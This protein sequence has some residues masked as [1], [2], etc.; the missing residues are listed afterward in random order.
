[1]ADKTLLEEVNERLRELEEKYDLL[2][3]QVDG[4][5]VWPILR[6]VVAGELLNYPF[7]KKEGP[8]RRKQLLRALKGLSGLFTLRKARYF[9]KTYSSARMEQEDGLYKDVFFD[10]LLVEL[11][12]YFKLEAENNNNFLS[13]SQAAFIKSDLSTAPIDLLTYLLKKMG[14]R[15]DLSIVASRLSDCLQQE[16][17]LKAF[18]TQRVNSYIL[19]FY[20]QKKVYTWLLRRVGPK[21]VLTADWGEWSIN[22]AAKELGIK[23]IDFQHGSPNRYHYAYSWSAYAVPYKAQMP[24][25]TR[26][27]LYGEYFEQELKAY[28]FWNKELCSVGGVRTNQY[29]KYKAAYKTSADNST[30]TMVVTSQGIDVERIIAFLDAFLKLAKGKLELR[31][32]IKPHPVYETS[33]A[34]YDAAFQ[35]D[36]RVCILL[37]SEPPSTFELLTRAD[38]NLSIHSSCHFDALALGVP[39]VILPLTGYERVLPLYESGHAFLAQTPQELLDIVWQSKEQ[40][41]PSEV[42]K[43]Y[44]ETNALENMKKELF[45]LAKDG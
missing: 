5:C 41:V 3:Y 31:L 34:I 14:G 44:C 9:V 10:D 28:D 23:I 6:P 1:M 38:L 13:R 22:A 21:Y 25:P 19:N 12:N 30:Y 17:E 20:W 39:T 36:D 18:T 8:S 16:R 2:Q 33:K 43:W 45:A 27:F 4:W 32:Y 15:R 37:G 29:R 40:T 11:G 7:I 26:I 42:S 24:I 35:A